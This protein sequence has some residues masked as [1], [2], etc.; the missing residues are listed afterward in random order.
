M[1]VCALLTVVLGIVSGVLLASGKAVAT[2]AVRL[3]DTSDAR[4]AAQEIGSSMEF[5]TSLSIGGSGQCLYAVQPSVPSTTVEWKISGGYLTRTSG[6]NT[7]TIISGVTPPSSGVAFAP[8]SSANLTTYSGLVSVRFTVD[9]NTSEDKTGM[10]VDDTY[11]AE[12]ASGA[13]ST[14]GSC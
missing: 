10:P 13:V 11:L 5:A 2:A 6:S 7:S 9:Q 8:A 1:V 4:T 12:N 3:G 14:S